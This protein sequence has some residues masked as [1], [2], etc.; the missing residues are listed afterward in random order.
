MGSSQVFEAV[1][2][3]ECGRLKVIEATDW[4]VETIPNGSPSG[5][6]YQPTDTLSIACS[7][8]ER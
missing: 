3:D 4:R 8:I 2:I 6:V 7:D 5:V 1:G